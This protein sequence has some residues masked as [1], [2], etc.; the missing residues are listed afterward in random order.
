MTT[1]VKVQDLSNIGIITT[2]DKLVGERVAG[3]TVTMT[4]G[5]DI[6]LDTA[7]VLGGNLGMGAYKIVD[8]NGNSALNFTATGGVVTNY[9][10]MVN[11]TSGNNPVLRAVGSDTDI[12]VAL[13]SKGVGTINFQSAKTTNQYIFQYGGSYANTSTFNFPANTQIYTFPGTTGTVTV[14]GNTTT[15]SNSIVL[16]TSPTLV[17]PVLGTPSSGTLSSCTG[18]A[19]S[20]LTGLGTN[21]STFLGTPSSA[22]LAAALTDETGS[23]AAV[24]ANTPTLITPVLGAATATS[25]NFG[26]N[27]LSNYVTG[28]FTPTLA[29]S[30][31]GTPT[32]NAQV[33]AYTRIGNRLF[34]SISLTLSTLGTLAAG[35]IS[36]TGLPIAYAGASQCSVAVWADALGATAITQIMPFVGA[37]APSAVT[38][39]KYSAG[40]ATTLTNTDLTTS[41][42][43]FIC[44]NYEV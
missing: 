16:S 35:N 15:G 32:Y 41:S 21:V 33:G 14:L 42:R 19:Q 36:L 38:L 13:R 29:S 4:Y 26:D 22:N 31:G 5:V 9:W 34:F 10:E 11:E 28:T 12:N 25:I 40:T 27:T 3:T 6:T 8:S 7:P 23:G 24:F 18:Y 1:E 30:G 39:Y 37:G 20:A 17:T 43:F 2:G 44:G